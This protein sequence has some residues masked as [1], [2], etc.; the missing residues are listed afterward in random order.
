[1]PE[2]LEKPLL[3]LVDGHSLAFRSFYAFSKGGEGGLATKDGRP[4]SVTYGFLKALLDNSKGLKP[5]GVAIAFDTAEP[6]FRHQADANYKAHRDVAPEVFFQDLDQLQ[7]ILRERLK[8]PL[9][10]APG[11]EADDVLGTLA[12]RA[13]ASG[14]R[15]RILS[16]DRDLFQLVDDQRDIAVLYM[17][18][19]PYAKSSGPTLINEAGV[20]AKLGVMPDKVV[21]LKALTGDSSD[22][23]PGVRGVGPKTAINLLKENEDLDGVYSVLEEVE[24]EGP[25]ASR[26]A[27]KGALKGKLSADR[28]NAYLSRHL[29]EILIDIP[30][31]EEPVLELGPVDGEGLE[32]QLQDLELNSL[33]R[34]IP[35]F[36]ATF[37]S[38]GLTANA[39]LLE[40]AT[41]K[42]S[43]SKVAAAGT[44]PAPA[45]SAPAE[46]IAPSTLPQLA[47]QVV[48]TQE[49]L[50]GLMQRLMGCTNPS[51]PV[52]V[53]TETTDL[54]PF[55]A[56]LVGIGVC[57][58][59]G[60]NDLAYLPVG[61]QDPESP[62]LPLEVVLEQLAPWLN[63]PSHP[64]AL[65]NA[66]YDRLILL[67]HGLLLGGVVMDTLLA[68]YLRDAA[69]KHSLD[70]M[71]ERDYGITPT[72]FGDLVGKPKDG[73]ASCFAEVPID[74]AALYCAMDVHL[75]RKLAIDLRQQLQATSQ[76]L[77]QLLDQVELPLEPVLALM[78]A[79]GIRIDLTYL[80]TLS[81]EMGETLTRLEANAKQAAGVDFNLASPKQ[82]GELLFETLGL[83]RKKSRRTKTG[84]STDATVLDK[85]ADD[86]PVVPLVLEH[87]VLSKLKSTYVDALPQLV[88]AETGRVHTDFN[89]AVTATGRL[90]S[91]NP[92]LQNIPIRTEY[93]RRIRKAFLPQEHWTLLSADYSQIELR[94]L[95][96]LS[97]EEV[98]LQAYRDGDD[99]HALTAR[100]LLEKDEVSADERRLGKTINFGVIYGMGA[101]R[102]ARET[103]VSQAE[104]KEFLSK[105]RER[106]PKVFAFLELQERLALSRGYVETILGRR[107]PFH[108]DRNGLG[109]LL[110]KDPLEI[111]LDVARRGGM[112][113]QQLRAAANAPI[114]GS[115][116]DI[117]KLAMIQLQAALQQRSL[118][119][120]LLLQV[121]D[122]LVLEVEPS[123]LDNVKALVVSTMEKAVELSVPLVAETGCGSNWMEAK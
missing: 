106:Y 6:T 64:K 59:A 97:G 89:Q 107:R 35:S 15:V 81:K 19:G 66:K 11:Y 29:A 3:L 36:V 72:V 73:K 69:A 27:L 111:D 96:H 99:V 70:V 76:Q 119:A 25:K 38:G 101:Q 5:K 21:D 84:Y 57:W 102:F 52:A 18:G 63:S 14:W 30:L 40:A 115:S 39:H 114:Q 17:G 1:M 34:Q 116:A 92:N 68:D 88:E 77:T 117:I 55:K 49:Q 16:G 78:E 91:S 71:A 26:G 48:S 80:D 90:S 110:G 118:P 113:A 104:A 53:D 22:N 41:S 8:L 74:Q 67:R 43:T 94:I 108:F 60:L 37:S 7:T 54:N 4:T 85:L 9:C 98:L 100:L 103:G 50:Q 120:R 65:Q 56:Q 75:T 10:L 105:Y 112:E 123:A 62:Q 83:D 47:P 31:P 61:H 93:S 109:R 122:E 44:D 82:L 121:H 79:T 46:D 32:E 23:I 95:T 86:H 13:A 33:V 87:R 12:N 42:G 51:E 2:T 28:D 45:L 24:A 20:V 58:G